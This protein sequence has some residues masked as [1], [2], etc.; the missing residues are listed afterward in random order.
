MPYNEA[1]DFLQAVQEIPG[2]SNSGDG[3]EE[4]MWIMKAAR[5]NGQRSRRTYRAWLSDGWSEFVDLLKVLAV[6]SEQSIA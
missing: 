4:K 5:S 6:R 3:D 2:K 1:P